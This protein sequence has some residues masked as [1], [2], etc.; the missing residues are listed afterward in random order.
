M[1]INNNN[2]RSINILLVEDNPGD[3]ILTREAFQDV[4][5]VTHIDVAADGEAALQMLL[6]VAPYSQSN[7]PDLILLD[8]NL[9]KINGRELLSKIKNHPVLKTIP[10]IVLS[11][12]RTD[13]DVIETYKLHANSYI[14]KPTSLEKFSQVVKAIEN[15]WFSIVTLP[16][17]CQQQ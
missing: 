15:F 4:N 5:L 10:V 16:S 1:D 7:T 17:L 13:S 11:S 3:V 8:L 9:P 14:P 12:S 6:K 2:S